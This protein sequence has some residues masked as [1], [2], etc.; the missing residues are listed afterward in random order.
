MTE[1]N[2]ANRPD[3][4]IGFV[5]AAGTDLTEVK[6][7]MEAQLS[8][9]KYSKKDVKVSGIISELLEV[10]SPEDEFF[11]DQTI[12]EQGRSNSTLLGK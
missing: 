2:P 7:Q 4:Y 8:V 6:A 11:P 1:T 12:Y 9:V 10:G 5:C 3:L